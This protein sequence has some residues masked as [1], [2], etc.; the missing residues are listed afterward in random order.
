M[1]IFNYEDYIEKQYRLKYKYLIDTDSILDN[2]LNGSTFYDFIEH[3]DDSSTISDLFDEIYKSIFFVVNEY[4]SNLDVTYNSAIKDLE[5]L[6]SSIDTHIPSDCDYKLQLRLLYSSLKSHCITHGFFSELNTQSK[7]EK[8][9]AFKESTHKYNI[10]T[11]SMKKYTTNNS[12]QSEINLDKISKDYA[13]ARKLKLENYA[14]DLLFYIK[15]GVDTKN[16]TLLPPY[17]S[18]VLLFL[19]FDRFIDSVNKN[20]SSNT[21]YNN[22]N[23]S[24]ESCNYT[25]ENYNN[26][27]D[28]FI[29]KSIVEL[30]YGYSTT[31]YSLNLM[32]NNYVDEYIMEHELFHLVS[33]C[34]AIYTRNLLMLFILNNQTNN[35]T[36]K[37]ITK[38]FLLINNITIP[39]LEDLWDVITYKLFTSIKDAI[40]SDNI[41]SNTIPDL[42]TTYETYINNNYFEL[43]TTPVNI[44]T[45]LTI[46]NNNVKTIFD[47]LDDI[48]ISIDNIR[49]SYNDIDLEKLERVIKRLGINNIV[50]EANKKDDVNISPT[51]INSF[52]HGTITRNIKKELRIIEKSLSSLINPSL[53]ENHN[54]NFDSKSKK[55]KNNTIN[56]LNE[57]LNI[58]DKNIETINN[59]KIIY[60]NSVSK[61]A[62]QNIRDFY[63]HN[64][65]ITSSSTFKEEIFVQLK[66]IK[67]IIYNNFMDCSSNIGLLDMSSPIIF[68]KNI[69]DNTAS[70]VENKKLPNNTTMLLIQNHISYLLLHTEDQSLSDIK[71]Y[72]ETLKEVLL[73]KSRITKSN[74]NISKSATKIKDFSKRNGR[75]ISI[76]DKL[77][78]DI[79]K[80]NAFKFKKSFNAFHAS[81]SIVQNVKTINELVEQ[82]EELIND[83]EKELKTLNH[84]SSIDNIQL[85]G[86]FNYLPEKCS[87]HNKE[88]LCNM[89][90]NTYK[91]NRFNDIN[92]KTCTPFINK[93]YDIQSSPLYHADKSIP[94]TELKPDIVLSPDI[95]E[96]YHT[97]QS[98]IIQE[99]QNYYTD[100][101]I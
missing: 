1:N 35:E 61:S 18:N 59:D 32:K 4:T 45:N 26:I 62:I 10:L 74:N 72:L 29:F 94:P 28:I 100:D 52:L 8:S 65:D 101:S 85:Y 89:F 43:T 39:V 88:T 96:K 81:S 22:Y 55:E 25:L 6:Y 51:N 83:I 79:P 3:P 27:I 38:N 20:K 14:N 34:P 11:Y 19:L 77:S 68:L 67:S 69:L 90:H 91:H 54:T 2:I 60:N 30:F 40:N 56:I 84:S 23:K 36:I 86:L 73:N 63:Y 42:L 70:F 13:K 99:L 92:L 48:R 53:K 80:K 71:P 57:S 37:F 33:N 9:Y 21:F 44:L 82:I 75:I 76:A 7:K 95:K 49:S 66:S 16:Y 12:N 24:I 31:L 93:S 50:T 47:L 97:Y 98:R 46:I 78:K 64:T 5:N 17:Y 58:L 87:D 15:T 41:L